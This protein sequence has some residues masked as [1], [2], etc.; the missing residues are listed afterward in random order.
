MYDGRKVEHPM[1]G[2]NLSETV[3]QEDSDAV[4]G[5]PWY[6]HRSDAASPAGGNDLYLPARATGCEYRGHDFPGITGAPGKRFAVCLEF[7]GEIICARPDCKD[8]GKVLRTTTWTVK[9]SGRL[10]RRSRYWDATPAC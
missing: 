1:A 2:G 6:G 7:R 10:S 5:R 3:W 9:F 4:T 8:A